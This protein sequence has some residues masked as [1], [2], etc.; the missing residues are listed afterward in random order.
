MFIIL[1]CVCIYYS[2]EQRRS[3]SNELLVSLPLDT[4]DIVL[5]AVADP[6]RKVDG[7]ENAARLLPAD[8]NLDDIYKEVL[9]ILPGSPHDGKLS[10]IC[11]L[12]YR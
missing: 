2:D 3:I 4:E 8:E 11:F 5:P 9:K 7:V 1:A 12:S 6:D 10:V